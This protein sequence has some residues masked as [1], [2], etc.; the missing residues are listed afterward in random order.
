MIENEVLRLVI[1]GIALVVFCLAVATIV[2]SEIKYRKER[3]GK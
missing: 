1:C 2:R 3:K